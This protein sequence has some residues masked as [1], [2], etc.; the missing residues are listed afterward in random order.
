MQTYSCWMHATTSVG[1]HLQETLGR[2]FG[3]FARLVARRQAVDPEAMS[4]TDYALLATLEHCPDEAGMRTSHLAATQ[5]HDV[6]TISRRA[7]HLEAH[8]LLARLPDPTDGRAS[9]VR[10]TPAGHAA[11]SEE[12]SARTDLLRVI[13]ADWPEDDLVALDR[14]LTRLSADLAA[15]A[16]SPG[17]PSSPT[18]ERTTA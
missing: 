5:G 18:P 1:L 6:S 17:L 13:L 16:E 8:G 10:L 3:Q 14:L 4:R 9:T 7:T 11:L 2:V 15:D 12:R